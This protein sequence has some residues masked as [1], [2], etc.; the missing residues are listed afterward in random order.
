MKADGKK[1]RYMRVTQ[2]LTILFLSVSAVFLVLQVVSFAVGQ[3]GDIESL[4]PGT[5]FSEDGPVHSSDLTGLPS[6]ISLMA[7]WDY[8]RS[9]HLMTAPDDADA[10]AA[11]SLLQEALGSASAPKTV[12][13]EAFRQ[14]L[15]RPGLYFD[16]TN[17][18][19]VSVLAAQ[20]GISFDPQVYARYFLIA[21]EE[22]QTVCLY[23]WSGE[24]NIYRYTTAVTA[25]ALTDTVTV[26]QANSALF[27]FEAGETMAHLDPYTILTDVREINTLSSTIPVALDMDS[28]LERLDFNP[29]TNSRY[30]QSDGTEVV[31]EAPRTL[32]VQ[33]DGTVIYT[34]DTEEVSDLYMVASSGDTP[35]EEE[36]VL[37]VRQLL[38]ELLSDEDLGDAVLY[39]SGVE[40][41]KGGMVVRFDYM[42]NGIP[43]YF[44][45]GVSA[46]E[47]EITDST[48]T[49]FQLKC[50]QYALKETTYTLLP[51]PLATAV[52]SVYEG[53]CLTVG[54]VD[55][56]SEEVLPCWMAN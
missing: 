28:L 21:L 12:G 13:E 2:N 36:G 18:L 3:D 34:G 16:Y 39:C 8:G 44:A 19:P 23:F 22:D 32:R 45:D 7:T 10:Q 43:V 5:S 9:G 56:G 33:T 51:L 4:L 25:T 30:P 53:G 26:F 6:P 47:A 20:Y 29:H 37:A 14:A 52:V 1:R 38:E 54:Y 49:A 24:G 11:I 50:R 41:D 27:A 15:N 42:V 55:R 35:T 48:I 17:A 40:T 31:V 46:M